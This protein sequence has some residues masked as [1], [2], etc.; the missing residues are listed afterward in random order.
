M[1]N[2]DKKIIK[3]AQDEAAVMAAIAD[4]PE[5]DRSIGKQL[6]ATITASAPTLSPRTWYGMPA[7]AND[8]KVL[9]YFRSTQ[10]FGERY[11]TL[12][13]ND[14]AHLDQGVMWPIVYAIKELGET[15]ATQ[16]STLIKKAVS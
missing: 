16:V 10:K 14:G 12:G 11:M 5:P 8:E 9:C 1:S 3:K 13:F 4:M 6:H 7:Y 15:E 2:T